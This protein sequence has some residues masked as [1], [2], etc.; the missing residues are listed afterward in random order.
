MRFGWRDF[1]EDEADEIPGK[2]ILTIYD[3]EPLDEMAVIVHRV[4]EGKYPL[5][6]ELANR[7]RADAQRIVDAL[8]KGDT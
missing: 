7:K 1:E 2:Y 5:D 4:C 3:G 6:G 8:N